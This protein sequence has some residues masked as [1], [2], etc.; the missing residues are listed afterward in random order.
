MPEQ[1]ATWLTHE[2]AWRNVAATGLTLICEDD[3]K[4]T[5]RV[6][7]AIS[8]IGQEARVGKHLER[9]EPVLLRLGR[10]LGPRHE[11]LDPFRF[12]AEVAMSNPCYALNEPMARMLLDRS[13]HIHTTVDIFVHQ[14]VGTMGHHATLDPP[15]AYELSWSTGE[16]RSDIR[17]KQVYID[18]LEKRLQNVPEG[19]PEHEALRRAIAAEVARFEAFRDYNAPREADPLVSVLIPVFNAERYIGEC[20]ESVC[21]QTLDAIE[22][23]C[24]DDGSWDRSMEIVRDFQKNDNR[25]RIVKHERNRGEGAARNTG[26]ENARGQYVFHLDADDYLP[27]TA[28]ERLWRT[29]VTHDSQLVKGGFSMVSESGKVLRNNMNAPEDVVIN[30]SLADSGFLQ[31]IPGSHCSYLYQ[32]EFLDE[33]GL[34]YRTDMSIGLDLVALSAALARASRVSLIPDVVY[35]YRQTIESATRGFTALSVVREDLKT[36][37]LVHQNLARAG[38]TE[39][40]WDVYRAWDWHISEYWKNLPGDLPERELKEV[41]QLFR[42]LIPEGFVPWKDRSPLAHRFFLTLIL[43]GRDNEAIAFLEE[44][45]SPAT[46]EDSPN[47]A[48]RCDDV[49]ALAPQDT[50]AARFAGGTGRAPK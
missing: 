13:G 32:R 20:L 12:T 17:P 36:K 49:L 4:F 33:Y 34:R 50:E 44:Y 11:S 39:A 26:L 21:G 30:T 23:V 1:V 16:L 48:Q 8:Y 25:V 45:R 31:R 42:A 46:F 5:D 7:E 6:G 43:Q 19:T 15:L 28:L 3:I 37:R 29:A 2:S 22:I 9:S 18:R 27:C 24:V 38:L 47:L 10:A 35:H 14:Q 41:F 40:A